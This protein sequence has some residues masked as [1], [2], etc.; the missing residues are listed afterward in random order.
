MKIAILFGRY[1]TG[2]RP[3]DFWFD[4]INVNMRGLTGSD[5]ATVMIAK[6]LSVRGHDVSL[7]T[8]HAQPHHKPNTWE[9][10]KLY[11]IEEKDTVIDNSFDSVLSINEPD[12]LRDITDKPLRICWQ[13]LNDFLYCQP[14]YDGFVDKWLGVCQQQVDYLK[15]QILPS[16]KWGIVGLGCSPE[17][18][19][20]KRVPGRVI[21]C[22]SADR[23]L[24]WL[25]Q[26]WP[27]IKKAVPY[28]SLRIFYHMGFEHVENIEPNDQN[29]VP[30]IKEMAN[31]VRYIKEAINKLKML[32]VEYVGSVSRKKLKQ[33]F[34]E[35]SVLGFCCDTVIFSEGFS[36]TALEGHA[37]FTV[38][39]ITDQDCLGQVYAG[40]G[41]PMIKSP[42][43]NYLSEFTDTVIKGLTD[44]EYSD[45]I[46]KN[47]REFAMKHTWEIVAEE[48]EAVMK[49]GK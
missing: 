20:D 47:C 2:Q 26:E 32:D 48:M 21:W 14:G 38:P 10:V 33:E 19:E 9:N 8:V 22:S 25:L 15:S 36:V 46:I 12:V 18:Y 5:L 3:L 28:A 17:I 24:H 39:V 43:K 4:N 49:A 27:K 37:S 7:F 30:F 23:G 40:S 35:A 16:D 1:S 13:F 45:D 11:N 41:A 44:K 34:N 29:T 42:V 6:E 31:R